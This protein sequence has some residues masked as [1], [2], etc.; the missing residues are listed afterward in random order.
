MNTIV[1]TTS[2]ISSNDKKNIY[3]NDSNTR[4]TFNHELTIGIALV[5][6][7]FICFSIYAVVLACEAQIQVMRLSFVA[8][9][10]EGLCI[11]VLIAI[12]T[13]YS[14]IY[15][16]E[17]FSIVTFVYSLNLF[18]APLIQFSVG[19]TARFGIDVSHNAFMATMIATG[20]Y[21]AF[22]IGYE[23]YHP[24]SHQKKRLRD[25]INT[26]DLRISQNITYCAV[27]IWILA[28]CICLY[29]YIARGYSIGY[30]V[31]AGFGDSLN[32]SISEDN[33]AFLAYFKYALVGSWMCIYVY[34]KNRAV[35][36][37]LFTLSFLMLLFGGS[38][39]SLVLI[40]LA[41]I[42]Y[43]YIK[44]NKIPKIRTILVS[45]IVLI[46]AFAVIQVTRNNV[47]LGGGFNLSNF[48]LGSLFTPYLNEIETY[49]VYYALFDVFPKQM[50]HLYGEQMFG[51]T[52]TMIIPRTL[53]P[54]K[55]EA[56][57]HTIVYLALGMEALLRGNA[58][59]FIGELFV[60]FGILGCFI[61]MLV[62]G[63]I[64]KRLILLMLD[65]N[66]PQ[67]SLII[68]CLS[69][70]AIFQ[71]MIRG[72]LPSNA[73]MVLF[74]I[75]PVFIIKWLSSS[76]DRPRNGSVKKW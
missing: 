16:F 24:Q 18:F 41:P 31:T 11:A 42:A 30:I 39:S 1:P 66:S 61:G 27:I 19:D 70:S 73:M 63:I 56:T 7:T 23:L 20:G 46:F 26:Q 69:F 5:I 9:A 64:C 2:T 68:Y 53:W 22:F 10:I 35:K 21:I 45:V 49:K 71:F 12:K 48:T 4:I 52:L 60:E 17:P 74:L 50:D 65:K 36:A 55:P 8:F 59:P 28:Y 37:A 38:R 54:N 33:L 29:N 32:D 13:H 14:G 25:P 57:I 3:E 47:K 40:L 75:L 58:Y 6:V 51:Q 34:G 44:R 62:F 76:I 15:L 43:Y 72:Y 67:F